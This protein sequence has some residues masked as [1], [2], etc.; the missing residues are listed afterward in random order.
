MIGVTT[1]AL[2]ISYYSYSNENL[3]EIINDPVPHHTHLK[4]I[5]D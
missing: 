1:N 5:R 3:I 4:F 2:Q